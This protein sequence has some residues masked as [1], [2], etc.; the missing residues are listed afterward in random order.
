MLVFFSNI[1]KKKP[2]FKV[3]LKPPTEKREQI[4]VKRKSA[5]KYKL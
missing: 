2:T 4:A 5:A 3:E 1:L